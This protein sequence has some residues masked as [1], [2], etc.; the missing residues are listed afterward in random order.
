M[1]KLSIVKAVFDHT[2]NSSSAFTT[3]TGQEEIKGHAIGYKNEKAIKARKNEVYAIVMFVDPD[4]PEERLKSYPKKIKI[5]KKD[6]PELAHKKNVP[7]KV[8]VHV[9]FERRRPILLESDGS[10]VTALA[11]ITMSGGDPLFVSGVFI[12]TAGYVFNVGGTR[13]LVSNRHV[14]EGAGQGN[15]VTNK[16][17][18]P[19]AKVT[20][21]NTHV[22]SALAELDSNIVF[23]KNIPGIGTPG[24]IR[25]G[26]TINMICRK[27]GASTNVTEF[28]ITKADGVF[29]GIP[30][31]VGV[32]TKGAHVPTVGKG[33]S[34]SIVVAQN[35]D[36]LALVFAGE[37]VIGQGPNGALLSEIWAIDISRAFPD[38]ELP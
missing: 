14:L 10:S 20:R 1:D 3:G 37:I 22:D 35:N 27:R 38:I 15:L 26:I 23:S 33:D 2:M 25:S 13:Q 30:V 21:L 7:D 11:A 29:N 5:S 12:G 8:A 18:K 36:I 6:I 34:G 24:E 4:L 17:G 16:E 9:R 19:L 32:N 28:N 31:V